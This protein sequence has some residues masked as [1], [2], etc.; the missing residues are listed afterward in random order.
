MHVP[1]KTYSSKYNSTSN[2]MRI[3]PQTGLEPWITVKKFIISPILSSTLLQIYCI[4]LIGPISISY[5]VWAAICDLT[6][7]LVWERVW[8]CLCWPEKNSRYMHFYCGHFQVLVETFAEYQ[9][10][11]YLLFITFGIS[12]YTHQKS[13]SESLVAFATNKSSCKRGAN[14]T[15][16]WQR[17]KQYGPSPLRWSTTI[18][19]PLIKRD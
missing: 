8:L 12:V 5:W 9:Y 3:P 11:E 18:W 15:P 2:Y 4:G 1:S 19:A 6:N 17:N 7:I 14:T 16:L 13:L 10:F